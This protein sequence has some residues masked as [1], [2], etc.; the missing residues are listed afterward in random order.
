MNIV[1]C[2][3]WCRDGSACAAYLAVTSAVI[4]NVVH[5]LTML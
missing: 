1:T 5:M 4:P 3:H 2:L